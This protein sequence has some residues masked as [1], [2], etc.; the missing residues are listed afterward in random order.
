LDLGGNREASAVKELPP[1]LGRLDADELV[2]QRKVR[3]DRLTP[4]F[5]RWPTLGRQELH[6]LRR[7]YAER[8]RIARFVGERQRERQRG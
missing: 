2:V 5:R 4:L 7:L 6:E 1:D 8:L 3:D